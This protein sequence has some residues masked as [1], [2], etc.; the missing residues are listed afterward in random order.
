MHKWRQRSEARSLICRKSIGWNR[1]PF[2]CCCESCAKQATGGQTLCQEVQEHWWSHATHRDLNI[3][4]VF[5]ITQKPPKK[6]LGRCY[7][8]PSEMDKMLQMLL[9]S[10][11]VYTACNI[12]VCLADCQI[13]CDTCLTGPAVRSSSLQEVSLW[14]LMIYF[15]KLLA[16]S[17]GQNSNNDGKMVG[18]RGQTK[19]L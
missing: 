7:A 11:I 19:S 10:C 16:A 13:F 8:C 17:F 18:N 5:H 9:E 3:G 12:N 15:S 1:V 2:F 4:R 14:W 6:G